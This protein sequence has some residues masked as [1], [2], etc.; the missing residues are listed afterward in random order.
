MR[1]ILLDK[2]NKSMLLV[3]TQYIAEDIRRNT[4][5]IALSI[6]ICNVKSLFTNINAI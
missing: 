1:Y 6:S 3:S 5:Y 4:V 2:R